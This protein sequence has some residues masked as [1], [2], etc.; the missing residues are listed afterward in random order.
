M[1]FSCVCGERLSNAGTPNLFEHL[2]I[3]N[4]GIEKLQNLVDGQTK[5]NQ[6]PTDDWFENWEDSEAIEVWKC[7][8]CQR[9]YFSPS[10]GFVSTVVYKVEQVG[11]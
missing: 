2:L 9:L 7:P 11:I 3:S 8:T 5:D 1:K 10:E 6:G 4:Q